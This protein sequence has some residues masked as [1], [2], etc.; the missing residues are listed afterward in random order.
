MSREQERA[1][2]KLE[3]NPVVEC[4]RIQR[5][6]YPELFDKF[7]KVKDPRNQSYIDYSI[8]T[9]LGT[10][11]YKCIGGISSMQEMTR[12]FN[13]EQ[14]V[15]NLYTFLGD[16]KKDYLPHGVTINE[17]LE[18]V[19]SEELEEIQKDM[20]YTMIR[21]K[22]FNDARVLKKW[23]IIVDG[24]EL[25]EGYQKKND[26]YLSRCYNRGENNEFTKYH[27]SMLEAK[28]YLGNDLVCSIASETIQN[29]GEYNNQGEE[30]VKQDCESKA[31]VRL[32][33]KIKKRFPRL[34]III[35][36]DGLYVSQRVIQICMDYG[37]E[38]IIR[39]KEGC[40]SS[41]ASEYRALPEKEKV[42]GNIEYQNGI[43]F[44]DFDVNLIYYTEKKISS[45]GEERITEFAWIT[46]IKIT[47]GNAKK[48]VQAGRKRWK[49]ENQGF[50]RQ[51]HWQGNI[52]H[53]CSWNERAQKN[54]YLMEQ[55]ADFIKQLYEYFYLKKNEIRKLQKNISS[56]LLASFDQQLTK[57]ED[58]EVDP[59]KAVT[60]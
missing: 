21:R 50:N 30:K 46:S 59:H 49:I 57:T 9:M 11:Y 39:Y 31:F 54:H 58:I 37:W 23:L 14:T 3:Q 26:C 35:M 4:N 19:P 6:Y 32:A 2:K 12:K 45:D 29:S 16:K 43:L 8:K 17:F 47:K 13:D 10:L 18:R 55:I 42:E 20:A 51:K 48:I 24:T 5:K 25:D 28:L 60:N 7:S 38:Y 53:A 15:E 22:T 27:R 33:E 41:I 36:A 34:P 56:E 40:A 52:E 1:K 44:G